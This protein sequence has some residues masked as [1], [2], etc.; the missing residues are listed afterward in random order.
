[1]SMRST[2]LP[3]RFHSAVESWRD[4]FLPDYDLLIENWD[5]FF[6]KD[7]Q[8]ELCAFREMGMCT[9]VE[10]GD[11]KG[12]PKSNKATELQEDQ[13]AHM[14]GAIRAQASAARWKC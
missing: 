14:L 12:Q 1:M 5:R 8:F 11:F 4:T 10:C 3:K 6:P 13:A 9:Q 7:P 2:T